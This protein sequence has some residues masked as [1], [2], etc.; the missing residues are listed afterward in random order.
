MFGKRKK[1]PKY[2]GDPVMFLVEFP[3]FP[4][5]EGLRY[6]LDPPPAGKDTIFLVNGGPRRDQ[7]ALYGEKKCKRSS[8]CVR[9]L[10]AS[11]GRRSLSTPNPE[12]GVCARR[13][14][15][16]DEEFF[17][18]SSD[19]ER[20]AIKLTMSK[21]KMKARRSA[22]RLFPA[23]R[24]GVGLVRC[25]RWCHH[26]KRNSRNAP[27]ESFFRLCRH[28]TSAH[29]DVSGWYFPLP[30]GGFGEVTT[31]GDSKEEQQNQE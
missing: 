4:E 24:Q 9:L 14:E 13:L 25:C 19:V 22:T 12:R 11:N 30:S 15:C 26:A 5:Q 17:L 31:K 18:P 2:T 28:A 20:E 27:S 23:V 7:E 8:A 29:D 6:T 10:V 3:I 21:T 1:P 16:D